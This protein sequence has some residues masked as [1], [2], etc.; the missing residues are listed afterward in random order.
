MHHSNAVS[1]D[2][3]GVD[4]FLVLDKTDDE[5]WPWD[6]YLVA[7]VVV[8]DGRETTRAKAIHEAEATLDYR[9]D[10]TA[11]GGGRGDLLND[12]LNAAEKRGGIFSALIL[13]PTEIELVKTLRALRFDSYDEEELEAAAEWLHDRAMARDRAEAD[14]D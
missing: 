2:E 9:R 8:D 12:V 13:D 5:R 10:E 6:W 1:K 14:A 4:L 3:D 11:F 7:G